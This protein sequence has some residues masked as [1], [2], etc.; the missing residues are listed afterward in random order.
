MP[1]LPA[2]ALTARLPEGIRSL[3]TRGFG[4]R[5]LLAS[6]VVLCMVTMASLQLGI[7]VWMG[8][9]RFAQDAERSAQASSVLVE[10]RV[11]A[12]LRPNA[13]VL[14]QIGFSA[15]AGAEQLDERLAL[16]H[17]LTAELDANRL[18][19]AAY[20][21]YE[22][23]DFM[24]ARPLRN[25]EA[26]RGFEAPDEARYL[27][28]T[29]SRGAK[30]NALGAYHFVAED[31]RLLISREQPGYRFDPRTRPWYRAARE[32]QGLVVGDPY[33]F[34]T[35][36]EVG[37]TLSQRSREGG[38]IV[39]VDLLLVD[40]SRTLA[41]QRGTK[42][43]QLLLLNPQQRVLAYSE[44]ARLAVSDGER[45]R[46]ASLD[47]VGLP[48]FPA[49]LDKAASKAH[50][51]HF[52]DGEWIGVRMPFNVGLG[53]GLQLLVATPM[54]DLVAPARARAQ[55]ARWIAAGLAVLLLPLGWWAGTV[56]ARRLDQ[57]GARTQRLVRFDFTPVKERH[58]LVRE[59]NQ[60]NQAI[61]HMGATIEAFLNLS[62]QMATEP[63]VE[64]MLQQVLEQL[65]RAT[66]AEAA[67]V[68]LWDA[69][70]Q[71]MQHTAQA[72]VLAYA[73]AENFSYPL[74]RPPRTG[75]RAHGENM[76]HLDLELRGRD[77]QLKGLLVLEFL[78]D[79]AHEDPA[80]LRFAAQLSGMLAVAIETRQLIEAQRRL[81]DAVIQLMADAIDAKSPYTGGHCERV[82][83][84]AIALVDRLNAETE[85]EFADFR[86]SESERYAFRLGAWL[87]DC[88][89]VTS[90]EHIV[91]K[92]TKLELIRNRIHEVR[93]RFEILWRDAELAHARGEL[94]AA[95]LAARQQQLRED[96]SFVAQCNVGGE[97]MADEAIA[98]LRDIGAQAWLRHFDD[99]LGLAAEEL[100]QLETARPEA[101]PL[102]APETLLADRPEH[103]VPWGAARPPVQ[104]DDPR[105]V[106]GFDMQLPPHK[107]NQGELHNLAV[108]RGTLTEEDRFK[109]NDH[110][111]QTYIML[112]GLPW[113][114]GLQKVPELAATHHER[115]DGK[116][117][118]RRL[119]AE[120]LGLPDRVMALADVFEALTAADRPYKAPKTLSETLRIMAMMC[121]D[122]HLDPVLF[123]YFLRSRLWDEF[124]E[125]F[126]KPEQRDAVDIAAIESL[127]PA[128]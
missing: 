82:P 20:V 22:N 74:Q 48:A 73:I 52:A 4:L 100:R 118:P 89:K 90:P 14:R 54:E 59:V 86:L 91:D 102:P 103:L 58:S 107:Q 42:G 114:D 43:T 72:G 111:V 24:L 10:E 84:L 53:S 83:Q 119:P 44:P 64:R 47:S 117:Y 13:I 78:G 70:S 87:H 21:G 127:L 85:G 124:A 63:E 12:L 27:L 106:Y 93:L 68:F 122:R 15:L 51:L 60:L 50:Q 75:A 112:K 56:I 28:Q 18:L 79:S 1:I 77:G 5:L 65:T 19:S 61:G 108:R 32:Q 41:A 76:R 123:R 116:G 34:F 94:D 49:L 29:I 35:T 40:L 26:R 92:A 67:A 121:K 62:Q 81:F 30:G 128:A 71:R 2:N 39:G 105:N 69:A 96:F 33:L 9:G 55:R 115:L 120:R 126:M 104:R 88:G 80:F 113:P 16:R 98:R 7:N 17:V 25:A 95:A 3:L 6:L 11:E 110:I 31:G 8:R 125:R 99:R 66:Q 101:P 109:I 97:F 23:G 36:Q 45:V 46:L 37:L 57:L 38:S